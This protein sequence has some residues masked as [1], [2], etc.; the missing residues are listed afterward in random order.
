[1]KTNKEWDLY[2]LEEILDYK[3]LS[4]ADKL[5]WLK[6]ANRFCDI[7]IKGKRR[8]IWEKFREEGKI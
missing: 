1:M 5:R 7:A 3:R 6:E 4:A 2:S 8:R